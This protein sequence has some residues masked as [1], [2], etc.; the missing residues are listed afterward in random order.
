MF[1]VIL[2]AHGETFLNIIFQIQWLYIFN[3]LYKKIKQETCINITLNP[4][5]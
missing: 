3:V 4:Q 1:T 5:S 2:W